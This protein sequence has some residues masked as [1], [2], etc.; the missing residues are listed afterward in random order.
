MLK[1]PDLKVNSNKNRSTSMDIDPY[2]V[3]QVEKSATPLEIKRSYKKLCLKY[4]P[5]K[6]QQLKTEHEKNY[7]PQIQ[8]A[9]SILSD[10]IKRKRYDTIGSLGLS[11]EVDLDEVFDWK[12]YFSSVTE[13]ISIEMIDEDRAKYQGSE[14][15]KNDI[16]HNFEYYEGDFLRLFEV[17]PHLEF[18]EVQESR[19][20]DIVE[21][22]LQNGEIKTDDAM[23]K[24]WQKY[25]KSRKTKVRQMLKKLAKEAKQ[26]EAVAKTLKEKKKPRDYGDLQAMIQ[27]RQAGRLD[28]LILSL[29][30]KY[31]KKGNKRAEPDDDEFKR[32]QEK[33]T[34]KKRR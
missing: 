22:A 5:D 34:R 20:F 10:P 28:D 9:Y 19:V 29:E 23:D 17:I 6:I 21:Q 27:K 2:K 15:E 33:M 13:K 31:V 16:L 11:G 18:D 4:H 7:F 32:I 14:E 1:N 3:L 12:E 25:K 30:S 24:S 8:F 26:A